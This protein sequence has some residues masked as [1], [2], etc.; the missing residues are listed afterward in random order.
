MRASRRSAPS[1]DPTTIP[2]NWPPERPECL[3]L[4][5]VVNP[6]LVGVE[7]A[8]PVD[9]LVNKG[10]ML[11]VATTGSTTFAHFVSVSEKTQ[12]ESV[13]FGELAEQ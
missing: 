10:F 6:V 2:A 13:E 9:E 7:D 3:P 5:V 1:T 11:D 4:F 8:V 12:H